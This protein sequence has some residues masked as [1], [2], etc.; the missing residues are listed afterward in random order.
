MRLPHAARAGVLLAACAAALAAQDLATQIQRAIDASPAARAAFWGIRIVEAAGG[1]TLYEQNAHRFFVPASNTKLFTTA[2]AL[3]RLGAEYRF[4]T[5]VRA[6]APPDAQGRLRGDLVFYGGGDPNLSARA[7]PYRTGPQEGNPLR[8]IEE[9]A[10]KLVAAG[11]RRV[12]GGVV[13]DDTFYVWS[14]Y[15]EGWAVDDPQWEYGAPV[16]AIAINDNAFTLSMLPGARAGE[17]AHVTLTPPLELY[18]LDNRVRTV[19]RGERRRVTLDRDPGGMQLRLW[20]TFPAGGEAW[21]QLLGIE[22]PA[23]YAALALRDAL[24]SRGVAITGDARARHLFPNQVEDLTEAPAPEPPPGVELARLVSAPLVE[25]LRITDK[26]SQNLHAEMALRAVGRA[27][28]NV[29]SRE[30][31]LEEMKSFLAEAGVE[32]DGFY[33]RDGSGLSRLNLVTAATV[34][35]LLQHMYATP[36]R[37][38]WVNLLPVSG[39]DGTLRSR[40]T[41][42]P[43][44]GRVQAKTGTLS[45]VSALSGYAA[46]RDGQTIVFSILVNNYHPRHSSEVR[47]VMDRICTL[48]VE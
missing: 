5:S 13:G 40:F 15:A 37:E 24:A 10:D 14:P 19:A 42:T 21:E 4:T 18:R 31:G 20:G 36:A 46:R 29:G 44:A 11:L 41:G 3:T 12:E 23:L 35:K 1:A 8:A 2:L 39:Q 38:A 28:R 30:A 27:R 32:P 26:V 48:M 16:S 22:D 9:L 25:D 45:H 7:I 33:F 6:A 43:A 34:V 47:G 17:P